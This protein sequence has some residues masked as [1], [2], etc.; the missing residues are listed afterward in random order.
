MGKSA[1]GLNASAGT[2]Y[3]TAPENEVMNAVD[4]VLHILFDYVDFPSTQVTLATANNLRP[5][6]QIATLGPVD[7]GSGT[8]NVTGTLQAYFEDNVE[9]DKY[10]DF[11]TLAL[12]IVAE[13]GAGNAYVLDMPRANLTSGRTVASG[14]NADVIADMGFEAFRD[15]TENIT[16]RIT[17]FAA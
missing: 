3:V 12:S 14:Q 15:P 1:E 2:G 17:R 10:R 4:D 16:L 11:D 6:N 8:F 13:D 7:I 9:M 5:K